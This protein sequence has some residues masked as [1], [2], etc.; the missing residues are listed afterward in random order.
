MNDAT[1]HMYTWTENMRQ[2][3]LPEQEEDV[4][5]RQRP[6]VLFVERGCTICS[7]TA[8]DMETGVSAFSLLGKQAMELGYDTEQILVCDNTL[9]QFQQFSRASVVVSVHGAQIT[10]VIFL[11]PCKVFKPALVEISFRYA[12][13]DY[14]REVRDYNIGNRS[15]ADLIEKWED[16][17][18]DQNRFYYKAD[19]FRLATGMGVRYTEVIQDSL[20]GLP[21]GAAN[22]ICVKNVVVNTS[23]ILLELQYLMEDNDYDYKKHPSHN[24]QEGVFLYSI[25]NV[26]WMES[27]REHFLEWGFRTFTAW[28]PS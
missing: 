1:Q 12:W 7:R 10:N 20:I 6:L 27:L 8:I 17:C 3:Y 22:P 9:Q 16:D 26:N 15:H 21:D 14:P 19:F 4:C 2:L 28:A 25:G 18:P 5:Q 13:C 24:G 11:K 23:T